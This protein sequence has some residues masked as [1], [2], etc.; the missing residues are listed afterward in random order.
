MRERRKRT[1]RSRKN[2][3]RLTDKWVKTRILLADEAL[4]QHIPSTQRLNF[5]GLHRML[6]SYGMVYVKPSHGSQGRGV[7]RVERVHESEEGE[8][9]AIYSYQL[10]SHKRQFRSYRHFYRALSRNTRGKV[11]LVQKG[12]RL[13]SHEGRAFDLRIVV[14]RAPSGGWETTGIV[15][16]IAHPEKIV[17][18]GSQGGTILPVE[19]LLHQYIHNPGRAKLISQL[20]R[21]GVNT[22]KRMQKTYPGIHE[23]G[24]D[25]ALDRSLTPWILEVNTRPDHCPFAILRDQTMIN[26]IIRYGAA[27][28]R[29]YR[30]NCLK[31]K[32]G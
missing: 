31:A 24:L 12:I 13:L 25:V 20:E 2:N 17:T 9:A 29:T 8:G 23:I 1:V 26:R 11:Y 7:M 4:R 5:R 3:N 22:M 19:P 32:Q 28:G 27:Y 6:S 21:I 15:G 14:Q 18:N 16:R 10:G 30:L